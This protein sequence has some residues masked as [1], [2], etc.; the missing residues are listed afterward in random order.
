MSE[1]L[2]RGGH[3]GHAVCTVVVRTVDSRMKHTVFLGG[4]CEA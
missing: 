4:R 1:R 3:G 2:Q